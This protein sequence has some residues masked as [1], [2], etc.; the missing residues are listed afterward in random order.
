MMASCAILTNIVNLAV[1]C[2][3]KLVNMINLRHPTQLV[4]VAN[5]YMCSQKCMMS[6]L[7]C[8]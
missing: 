2:F 3:L 8:S 6:F 7:S 5:E 1:S 4:N